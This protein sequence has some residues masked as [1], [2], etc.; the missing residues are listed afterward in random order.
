MKEAG[1]EVEEAVVTAK[2]GTPERV[3][4]GNCG[5]NFAFAYE[6]NCVDM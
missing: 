5:K 2:R 1:L 4:Q 3:N 6:I